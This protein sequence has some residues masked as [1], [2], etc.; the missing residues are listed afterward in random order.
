MQKPSRSP[1]PTNAINRRKD[2]VQ[3][4]PHISVSAQIVLELQ[5]LKQNNSCRLPGPCQPSNSEP[6]PRT[7]RRDNPFS[8]IRALCKAPFAETYT[9]ANDYLV[10]GEAFF[11][12]NPLIAA[13]LNAGTKHKHA[14]ALERLRDLTS[15]VD[16]FPS[17]LITASRCTS[18]ISF[19]RTHWLVDDRK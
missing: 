15:H 17:F 4:Y 5:L 9:A 11:E 13:T 10:P 6:P 7:H 19:Y 2:W 18:K 3:M 1:S 12:D 8:T 16:D 14:L